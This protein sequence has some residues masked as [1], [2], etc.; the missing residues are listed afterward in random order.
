MDL[1]PILH[2]GLKFYNCRFGSRLR[3]F[4]MHYKPSNER[5]FSWIL[6]QKSKKGACTIH[7]HEY[8][9]WYN[10]N[11]FDVYRNFFQILLW[12]DFKA[13][14]NSLRMEALKSIKKISF[15]IKK[16]S[17]CIIKIINKYKAFCGIKS[18]WTIKIFM[19]FYLLR[20]RP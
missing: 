18:F 2:I 5:I 16:G 20:I 17:L 7:M 12:K 3:H 10:L 1:K 11:I 13:V 9:M 8:D 6:F 15:E 4:V 19:Y 14:E